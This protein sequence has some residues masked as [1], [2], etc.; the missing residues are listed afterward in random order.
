[1]LKP[2]ALERGLA[3]EVEKLVNEVGLRIVQKAKLLL[4]MEFV[5]T[6]YQWTVVHHY[7]ALQTYLCTSEVETWLVEGNGA[8]EK[9]LQIRNSV[10][11]KYRTDRL[12]TLL[13]CP[14]T[15]T[16]FIRESSLFFP[17]V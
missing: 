9:C 5:K 8:V 2:D 6:L 10:R 12:H 7:E 16:D 17:K 13:H 3:T 4:D 14:D 1:M 15:T 11:A